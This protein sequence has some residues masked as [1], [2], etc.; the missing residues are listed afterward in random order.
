MMEAMRALA[1]GRGHARRSTRR[2]AHSACRWDRSSS[3]TR[4]ASTSAHTSASIL[5]HRRRTARSST[6][7]SPP[8]SSARRRARASTS[9]RTAS[10][11]R[12]E[13][14]LR[15]G[16]ARAPR[17]RAGRAACST[18]RERALD[19]QVVANADLVDA[20]VIFGTGFA[21]FRGG[22]LHYRRIARRRPRRA[23]A[24]A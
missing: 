8:A 4:S 16:R 24:A 9:G 21:P 6:R 11:K 17:P 12:D 18:K 10:P 3:P 2:R 15:Q 13:T 22:P 5:R 23:Q 7:W 1:A 14:H 20:G 19:E